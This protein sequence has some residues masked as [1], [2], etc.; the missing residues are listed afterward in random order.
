M[1]H[2]APTSMLSHH[3]IRW[4]GIQGRHPIR[5]F[6]DVFPTAQPYNWDD[7]WE[8]NDV[9][10]RKVNRA[11]FVTGGGGVGSHTLYL[12]GLPHI[13]DLGF[14]V[15]FIDDSWRRTNLSWT[16]LLTVVYKKALR[17]V[18]VRPFP[19]QL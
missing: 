11:A 19:D 17:V 9:L 14:A 1:L 7:D 13:R 12:Q 18:T 3:P 6:D 2:A 8:Y 15:P 5:T 16:R 4:W 10:V